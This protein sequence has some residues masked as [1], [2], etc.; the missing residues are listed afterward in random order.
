[1]AEFLVFTLEA[2]T[3]A[4]GGPAG[5]ERRGTGF[6]PGRS[7][8]LGLLGA[9]LGVRRED[10]AGQVAL[11]SLRVAI[12]VLD[13]G[14]PLRD[15]HTAQAV[16][17]KIRRPNSR[18]EAL[19]AVG[20]EASTIVTRRDYVTEPCFGVALWSDAPP[21]P[22][23]EIAEALRRPVFVLFLGRKSCPLSAPL[24]PQLVEAATPAKALAQIRLPPWRTGGRKA[25]DPAKPLLIASEPFEGVAPDRIEA[26]WDQPLDRRLWHFGRRE[27]HVVSGGDA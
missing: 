2:P 20:R 18:R 5:H 23:G 21:R 27:V 10:D 24:G 26:W 11:D 19:A 22:L 15:F 1:M 25:L 4:F 17:A 6:W 13:P 9:A 14:R 7:A 3:G 8:V 16:P 12:S